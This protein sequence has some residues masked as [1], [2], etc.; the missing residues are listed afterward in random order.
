MVMTMEIT[1]TY[2]LTHFYFTSDEKKINKKNISIRENH[3]VFLD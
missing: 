1:H 3:L 2:T